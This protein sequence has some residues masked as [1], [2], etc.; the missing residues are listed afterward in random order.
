MLKGNLR[1]F[2]TL[3]LAIRFGDIVWKTPAVFADALCAS[4]SQLNN[5]TPNTSYFVQVFFNTIKKFKKYLCSGGNLGAGNNGGKVNIVHF[6]GLLP[7]IE[8]MQ[9]WVEKR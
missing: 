5:L 6:H 9:S 3:C 7:K 4:G 8:V 1:R 2:S